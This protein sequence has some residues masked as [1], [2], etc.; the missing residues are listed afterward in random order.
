MKAPAAALMLVPA[1]ALA[2]VLGLSADAAAQGYVIRPGDTLRVDVAEDESLNRTVLVLPDGSISFP[3]AGAVRAA[4][5]STGQLEAALSAGMASDFAVAPSVYVSVVGASEVTD[6]TINVYLMGEVSDPGLKEMLPGTTI[7]QA[8]S[9]AGG[10]SSFAATKRVQLRR[11]DPRSGQ[12][13]V[14]LI[15][16]RA[17]ASGAALGGNVVLNEGDVILVP[18]RRLFE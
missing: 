16:Y 15:D 7:L 12:E 18:E 17:L 10:F 8:L 6:A 11:H 1:L 5:R 3:Y 9:Q 2:L 14:Y 4:G 13:H